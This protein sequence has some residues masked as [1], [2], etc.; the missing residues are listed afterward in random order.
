MAA[1]LLVVPVMRGLT[2]EGVLGFKGATVPEDL[3]PGAQ[4]AFDTLEIFFGIIYTFEIV[5]KLCVLGCKQFCLDAWNWIDTAIVSS[6]L[7]SRFMNT[8]LVV[9]SQVLRLFRMFR[10]MRLLKLV[11]R[12]QQFDHL[13]MMTTAIRGSFGILAWTSAVL[14]LVHM[15]LALIVQQSLFYF[16]FEIFEYFGTFT[17][18]LLTFFELTLANFAVP[19]R[20][21]APWC[22]REAL[23]M[24]YPVV[25]L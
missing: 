7:I 8:T 6:W 10:L 23:P 1:P 4:A 5:F 12:I 16:Y 22:E 2:L 24:G 3:W 13:F 17:R 25:A 18:A 11:R 14:F 20:I 21:M 9:N 19:T 15:L